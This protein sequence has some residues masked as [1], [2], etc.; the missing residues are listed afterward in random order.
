MKRCGIDYRKYRDLNQSLFKYPF[1]S[2]RKRMS[3]VLEHNGSQ[4]ILVKG[5]SE[6]VMSSCSDWLNPVTNEI[7]TITTGKRK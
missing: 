3:V 5:A 7:E 4:I 6:M 2:A 1:S